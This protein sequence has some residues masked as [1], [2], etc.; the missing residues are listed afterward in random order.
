MVDIS[1]I[2]P[3]KASPDRS[4]RLETAIKSVISQYGVRATVIV[5]A[6]GAECD[7]RIL[8]ALRARSDL[9]VV[10]QEEGNYAEALKLGRNLVD[11]PY[12]AEIDDDDELLPLALSTRLERLINEPSVDVV[13]TNGFLRVNGTRS[14]L[15]SNMAELS[16]NP[17]QTLATKMWL[18]P[19]ATLYRTETISPSLFSDIPRYLEWTYLAA[20]LALRRKIIFLDEPT[21]I[22]DRDTKNSLSKSNAYIMQQPKAILHL[23]KLELPADVRDR[24][25]KKYVE[26]LHE[27]SVLRLG[28]GKIKEAWRWHLTSLRYH[29]G[30][31]YLSFTRRLV[32]GNRSR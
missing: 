6:N 27:A 2:L 9:R 7:P 5:I 1:V 23:L 26:A 3:T 22:Q 32:I 15:I 19:C 29:Y 12:F 24:F 20:V 8:A 17:L 25:R 28:E 11:T 18:A 4:L 16:L 14:L 30:W 10:Y 31:R 13:V 21:F